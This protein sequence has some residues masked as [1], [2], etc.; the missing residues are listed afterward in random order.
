[1][2]TEDDEDKAALELGRLDENQRDLK[3]QIPR[4]EV[5]RVSHPTMKNL[6]VMKTNR[7]F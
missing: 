5:L 1:M 3:M 2:T 7:N 6:K 4:R